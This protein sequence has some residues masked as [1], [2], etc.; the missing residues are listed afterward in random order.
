MGRRNAASP[1]AAA[2]KRPGANG[3]PSLVRYDELPDY[4][5]DNEFILDHY[6]SEWP[7]RDALLS[8]FAWHNETLNVWTHLGGFLL[9]L[10]ITVAGSI[11]AIEEVTSAVVPGLPAW[12]FS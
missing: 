10:A 8:A 3:R 5:K 7:I 1:A 4:L 2:G 9:F 11:E 12:V 6:R